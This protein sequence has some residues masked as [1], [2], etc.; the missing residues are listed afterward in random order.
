LVERSENGIFFQPIS[1]EIL[2][3][4]NASTGA[5]YSFEDKN[6]LKSSYYRIKIVD[7]DGKFSFS[8]TIFIKAEGREKI[9]NVINNPVRGN[10]KLAILKNN[11]SECIVTNALGQILHRVKLSGG[12]GTILNIDVSKFTNGLYQIT[13]KCYDEQQ[14][15]KII[16]Q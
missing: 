1:H 3:K 5:N 9:F 6:F 12:N 14:V 15:E 16:I 13:M 8:N 4:G 11:V 7:V 2:P 10:L